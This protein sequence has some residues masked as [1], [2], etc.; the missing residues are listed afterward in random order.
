MRSRFIQ[1][2]GHSDACSGFPLPTATPSSL[3]QHLFSTLLLRGK[4][5]DGPHFDLNAVVELLPAHIPHALV[6]SGDRPVLQGKH[7]E[8]VKSLTD[9]WHHKPRSEVHSTQ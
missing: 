1:A 8:G 7:P 2:S 3:L 5:C 9:S 6:G 4:A